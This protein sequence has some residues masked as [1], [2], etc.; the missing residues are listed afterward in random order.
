MKRWDNACGDTE[1]FFIGAPIVVL[2]VSLILFG[3]RDYMPAWWSGI[4]STGLIHTT[5]PLTLYV[6]VLHAAALVLWFMFWNS[7]VGE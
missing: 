1:L 4:V 7:E 5:E 3:L 6:S 2:G